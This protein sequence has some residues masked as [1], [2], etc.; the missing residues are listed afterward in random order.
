[1]IPSQ[2]RI[3]YARNQ[4]VGLSQFLEDG[5]LPIHNNMSELELRRE[6]VTVS[7]CTPFSSTGNHE[8]AIITRIATRATSI[9][10]PAV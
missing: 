10:S 7:L 1:M 5:R 9:L 8:R 2:V 4:R 3:R 6:A